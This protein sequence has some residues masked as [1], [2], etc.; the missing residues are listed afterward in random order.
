M[1]CLRRLLCFDIASRCLVRRRGTT[2]LA[3][4]SSL[5]WGELYFRGS[6][7]K[8]GHVLASRSARRSQT[9]CTEVHLKHAKPEALH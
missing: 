4:P 8:P 7:A 9:T 2:V 5:V 3:E 1:V 6:P